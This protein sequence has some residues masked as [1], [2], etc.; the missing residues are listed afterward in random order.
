MASYPL[1]SNALDHSH[2]LKAHI[3]S[4]IKAHGGSISF[5]DYMQIALYAPGLGYYMAG[6][7]KFG[8][9]GDFITAPEISPLFGYAIGHALRQELERYPQ[10][11]LLEVGAGSGKLASQILTYFTQDGT[12]F[13]QYY[14]LELSPDLK[15]RQ[16]AYL[17]ETVPHCLDKIIWLDHL[18]SEPFSGVIFGN[19]VLDALPVVRFT[20]KNKQLYEIVITVDENQQLTPTE[21]PFQDATLAAE[22]FQLQQTFGPWPEGYTSEYC[23]LLPAWLESLSDCLTKGSMLFIDYGYLASEYYRP[24]RTDGTLCCYH[25]H[26]Q[27]GDP[28]SLPG[29]QD[30]TAHVNFSQVMDSAETLGWQITQFQ[31]QA[32][33]LCTQHIEQ[34]LDSPPSLE[35]QSA[36]RH[37]LL[38]QMMGEM[39]KAILLRKNVTT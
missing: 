34:W 8:Q 26:R 13:D 39:F 18:P 24:E 28:F 10:K 7:Q 15:A 27:T 23:A 35:Q 6:Q 29:L 4:Q 36:L 14:I 11:N 32:E 21:Q 33:F 31:T 20:Q 16:Q 37:L 38:P 5:Q 17:T 2:K 3:I 19:E 30:I 9:A 22:I 1:S 12:R 25:Q